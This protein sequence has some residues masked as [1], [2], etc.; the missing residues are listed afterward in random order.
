VGREEEVGLLLKRWSEATDGEGQIVLLS[1]EAGIGKSRIVR[2]FR[3]HLEA[4]PHNRSLYYCSPYHQNSAFYPAIGQLERGLRFEKDD[5]AARKL[6]KLD[7]VLGDLGLPVAECAPVLASLLSVPADGRYP[8]LELGPAQLKNKTLNAIVTMI[9]AMSSQHPVLMVVEDVH[10]IDPSTQ[11]LMSLLIEQL[12]SYRLFLLITSRPE[13]E[14]PWGAYAHITSLTLNRLSQRDS[15]A[16]I[17]NVTAGKALPNEVLEQIVA[18]TDGVPLFVEELTKNVLE[19][20]L[21]ED[22]GDRYRL[23][24][25]LPPLAIPASLQDSLMARLDRLAP[26]KEVAQLGSTLG[27]RFS[28]ELLAAVSPLAEKELQDA[29]AQLAE[30][31]L[32]YRRGLSPDLTYEFKHALVQDVAYGSLLK[33]TRAQFHERIAGVL[34]AHFPQTAETEPEILAHHFEGADLGEKAIVYWRRAGELAAQRSA[35]VEAV[36]HFTKALERLKSLPE[37]AEQ[38]KQELAL[39]IGLGPAL[40]ATKG[41]AS[42]ELA[43]TYER[44]R[45]LCEQLGES[46]RFPVVWG[47]WFAKNQTGQIS[48]ACALAD[49]LLAIGQQ[50]ADTGVLL[51][52]HHSVWTSRF[53]S[54]ELRDVLAH[55][56]EGK[57][58]YDIDQHRSHALLYGGH[59]PGVCCRFMGAM[60][61]CLLGFPNQG[62]DWIRDAVALAEKLGHQPTLAIALSFTASVYQFRREAQLVQ[63][64]AERLSALCAEHGFAFIMAMATIARGWSLAAQGQTEE[65]IEQSSAG[66]DALR[67]TGIRRLSFQLAIVAESYDWAGDTDKGLQ[68]ADEALT[69]VNETSEERWAPEVYR[70]KGQLLLAKAAPDRAEAE[71]CFNRAIELSRKQEA[72]LFE[73]RAATSLG[74]LWNDQGK[75]KEANELLAPIYSWFTQGFDTADLQEAEVLLD[76]LA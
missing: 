20:G 54:G 14:S 62:R 27:R 24:G 65:G 44:A 2:A 28:H 15:T 63:E 33:S 70:L 7:A 58:L 67:A 50:Q 29:L 64:H 59:D 66:L 43:Q 18:K 13:F 16:M 74:R 39:Q 56:K 41:P 22:A 51:E 25:S 35:N 45:V 11:E 47:L 9:Q 73:L 72:K 53:A 57:A 38:D 31:E 48:E 30:A 37:S 60:T 8:P 42:P 69:V 71:I 46:Q 17:G 10:W 49:E 3:D 34:E 5:S 68:A 76:E 1:G 52:A 40:A 19:S 36:N 32:I 26:V 23:S 12:Q 4:E 61:L 21:L 6:E 55:T 75:R